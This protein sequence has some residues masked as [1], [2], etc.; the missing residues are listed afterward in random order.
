[1]IASLYLTLLTGL[2][3]IVDGR[4][5]YQPGYLID[6]DGKRQDILIYDADWKNNPEKFRYRTSLY[7]DAKT[8]DLTNVREFG[9]DNQTLRYHRY[10]VDIDRPASGK[11]EES[12]EPNLERDT[13]FLEWLV[14]GEADLFYY[15][16]KR[17][18]QFFYR[19][20][21]ENPEPLL[22]RQG[23]SDYLDELQREMTCSATDQPTVQPEYATNDLVAYFEAYNTCTGAE[24]V[25]TLRKKRNSIPVS[26]SPRLGYGS[27]QGHYR[28]AEGDIAFR[29]IQGLRYGLEVEAGLPFAQ[30]HF[31]VFAE[32]GYI[33]LTSKNRLPDEES[34]Y[35]DYQAIYV[36]VGVRYIQPLAGQISAHAML[37]V[38]GK[39]ALNSIIEQ[40]NDGDSTQEPGVYEAGNIFTPFGGVGLTFANRIVFDIRYAPGQNYLRDVTGPSTDVDALTISLGYQVNL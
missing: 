21:V 30:R 8:G 36:P 3:P 35:I 1:M 10:V 15:G 20:G 19:T 5:P 31:A 26:V 38:E 14:D 11:N 16:E 23:Q 6:H 4:S 28:R 40:F 24:T 22:R 18:R 33:S 7:G 25:T 29:P 39:F 17:N 27:Y 12:A 9:Y 13:V 2:S 32:A 34:V 37:G